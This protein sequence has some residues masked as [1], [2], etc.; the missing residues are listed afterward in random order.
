MA[1]DLLLS[2]K[3]EEYVGRK[4]DFDKEV[5]LVN[6]GGDDYIHY[7]NVSGKSKPTKS[8]LDAVES[9]AQATKTLFLTLKKRKK[10]Y[11]KIEDQLDQLYHDMNA[12]KGDKTGEW[13][14]AV[15]K[16]KDDNPK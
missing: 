16:V 1:S 5:I 13:F 6:N 3:I 14:K 11:G 15:K 4:V 7:W 2:Y 9:N 10:E 8:Q 12:G